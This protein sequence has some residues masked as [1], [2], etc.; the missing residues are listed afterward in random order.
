MQGIT[1]MK[2]ATLSALYC[3]LSIACS[4]EFYF[5][6]NNLNN[7]EFPGRPTAPKSDVKPSIS[8]PNNKEL[9]ILISK[10]NIK[11]MINDGTITVDYP[12]KLHG[13]IK[14]LRFDGDIKQDTIPFSKN[15]C[16][17]IHSMAK[18]GAGLLVRTAYRS[19][20]SFEIPAMISSSFVT[21]LTKKSRTLGYS[22]P[23]ITIKNP[24]IYHGGVIRIIL[25]ENSI[26]QKIGNIKYLEDQLNLSTNGTDIDSY[27]K[28]II[29][30]SG[31][32]ICDLAF[33]QAKIE[34]SYPI[35]DEDKMVKVIFDKLDTTIAK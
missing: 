14:L 18:Y 13:F 26:A 8:I 9:N 21:E 1:N 23:E 7:L 20:L 17:E 35:K 34:I 16:K 32:I 22:T 29:V 28:K 30:T 19:V 12:S 5:E 3:L 4:R 33:G 15:H 10:D 25:D 11:G 2:F 24:L 6:S 31:D 27:H